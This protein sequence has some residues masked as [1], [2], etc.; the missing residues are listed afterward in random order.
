MLHPLRDIAVLF[1]ASDTGNRVLNI[2]AHLAQAQQAH[3]VAVSTA[4][5]PTDIANGFARG[6]G[7]AAALDHEA[8][9]DAD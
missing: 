4:Q 1:D 9:A 8:R 6:A 7:I 2:A 3:L 5:H